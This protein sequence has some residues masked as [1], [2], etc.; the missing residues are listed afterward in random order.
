VAGMFVLE[1][2]SLHLSAATSPSLKSRSSTSTLPKESIDLL[3]LGVH[4]SGAI[5]FTTGVAGVL[6]E[7]AGKTSKTN[8]PSMRG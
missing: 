1:T 5:N 2:F 7:R 3:A 4:H 8:G 6:V